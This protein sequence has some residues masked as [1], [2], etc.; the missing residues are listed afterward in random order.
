MNAHARQEDGALVQVPIDK[1]RGDDAQ[2][3]RD[4]DIE[5]LEELAASVKA[6]G[7]LEPME[8]RPD[9][10]APS[11][12][13]IVFGERR[14]RAAKL[15]G[16]TSVPAIVNSGARQVRRR[17]LYENVLRVDLNVV[18][19][20]ANVTAVMAEEKLETKGLA[21][22]LRWPLRRVQ[23]LVEIHAAPDAVKRA[24][25]R[26]I[27]VEAGRRTLS[28]RHALD[29]LRAYRHYAREDESESKE[30][31]ARLDRLVAKVL[32]ED[33]S[34]KKLQEY[35]GALGRSP[36]RDPLDRDA[37]YARLEGPSAET[38]SNVAAAAAVTPLAGSSAES[39]PLPLF[40]AKADRFTV[41]VKRAREAR[42]A[43]A[44]AALA[45]ALRA[46]ALEFAS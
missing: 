20:A 41:F 30:A 38:A 34:A 40:E 7:I 1:I 26:G 2:T 27:D 35:V 18:E 15:A 19:L 10:E 42:D 28:L 22:Q 36:K 8:L 39:K 5:K 44:R 25:V 21:E 11:H 16:L 3:R 23:R 33:W 29:V 17:Q 12:F 24:I 9:P 6:V 31:A 4:F 13:I 45:D 32:E 14:W 43:A 46:V 37:K